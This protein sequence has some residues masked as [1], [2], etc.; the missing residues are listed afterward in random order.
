MGNFFN[1]SFYKIC[2]VRTKNTIDEPPKMINLSNPIINE[3]NEIVE[4]IIGS[5]SKLLFKHPGSS[6]LFDE[7]QSS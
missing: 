1:I 4:K 5:Q 6:K 7:E 3:N 2:F